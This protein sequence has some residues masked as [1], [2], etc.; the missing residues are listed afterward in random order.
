MPTF[1]TPHP[2]TASVDVSGFELRLTA[3]DVAET[4]VE[5]R[6]HNPSKSADVELAAGVT[7]D[8]TGDRLVVRSPRTA[9]DRLRSL[10]GGGDRVDIDIT[11]PAGSTLEV[12]GWG[13]V[14]THGQLGAVDVDLDRVERLRVKTSVGDVTVQSTDGPAEL[15]TSTGRLHVA[16]AGADVS[17][18]S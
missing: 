11:V 17:A 16:Q 18:K 13:D 12:R 10:F 4:A 14:T 5:V 2:V 1:S 8:C 9:R 15:H 3:S 6:P 7:V